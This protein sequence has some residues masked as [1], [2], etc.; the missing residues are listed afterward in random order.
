VRCLQPGR[1]T[2]APTPSVSP[3]TSTPTAP[4]S[5]V[6]PELAGYNVDERAAYQTAVAEYD[7]FIKRNDDFYAAGETTAEAK[8]FYQNYA[9]DWS[10]AWGN[11]AQVVNSG[12]K[13]AGT[14]RTVWT[15][16]QSI[17]L[18]TAMGDVIVVRRCLARET[19]SGAGHRS[20]MLLA[21]HQTEDVAAL[22]EW[23]IVL[24]H[25]PRGPSHSPEL[26][27]E[28]SHRSSEL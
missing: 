6:P 1:A 15:K 9:I 16:P 3:T 11:L 21:S 23:V 2:S 12:V 17:K 27:A 19:V 10:T 4:T 14:T 28:G 8:N 26:R 22:C 20:T 7:A 25:R 5:S 24:D 18:G 13:V